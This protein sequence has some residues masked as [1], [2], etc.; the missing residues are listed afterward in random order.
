MTGAP[1]TATSVGEIL[2]LY[3]RWGPENYDEV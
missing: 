2:D 1:V 3:E